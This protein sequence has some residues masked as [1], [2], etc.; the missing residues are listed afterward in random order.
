MY[1]C[2]WKATNMKSHLYFE[3]HYLMLSQLGLISEKLLPVSWINIKMS[4]YQYRKSI[5]EIRRSYDSLLSTIGYLILVRR[6]LYIAWGPWSCSTLRYNMSNN[7]PVAIYPK[8]YKFLREASV[9]ISPFPSCE[10]PLSF[11]AS[12]RLHISSTY[13]NHWHHAITFAEV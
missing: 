10:F 5:M 4:S 2:I 7:L 13:R 1:R 6:H 8:W 12:N 3:W 11:E 9:F